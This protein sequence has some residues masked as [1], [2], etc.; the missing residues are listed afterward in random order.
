MRICTFIRPW[1]SRLRRDRRSGIAVLFALLLIPM[2]GTVGLAVDAALYFQARAAID[3]AANSAVMQAMKVAAAG[4]L[5]NDANYKTEGIAAGKQWFSVMLGNTAA[6]LTSVTPDVQITGGATLATSLTATAQVASVFGN[7]FGITKY[8]LTVAV[9]A[10]VET[11]PY[12]QVVLLLDD[13]SSMEIGASNSD[14]S[15]LSSQSPCDPSNAYYLDASHSAWSN[16]SATDYN[17]YNCSWYGTLYD[18]VTPCPVATP[19]GLSYSSFTPTPYY[20]STLPTQSCKGL[21]PMTN[22][23][24]PMTGPPCAFACHWTNTSSTDSRGGTADLFGMARRNGVT[25]R[26]DIL[27][28]AAITLLNKMQADNLSFSNLSVGIYTFEN[29]ITQIYPANCVAGTSGCE[30]GNDFT[31]AQALVGAPPVYPDVT[32][33]GILPPLAALTGNNDDTAFPEDMTSLAN[34]YVTSGGDGTSAINP[35]KVLFL[36]TD[37]FQD[38]PNLSSATARSAFDSSYCTRFKNMGYTIYVAYTPY[39]P[40]MHVVYLSKLLS[41]VE[42]SG[43]ATISYQLKACAS[44]SDDFAAVTSQ[45][46]LSSAMLTFLQQ[47]LTKAAKF[48]K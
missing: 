16:P 21:L 17:T 32:D 34:T 45:S 39:Y 7:L 43:S 35:K 38:D 2:A 10:S 18:G 37:G 12:V 31:S 36:I 22:G 20:T 13:L 26:F 28:S 1:G 33:T 4:E 30:A 14:I 40:L 19:S 46:E 9:G 29:S 15:T 8:H 42:G 5:A 44:S 48:T 47:A 27:K 3:A 41:I 23:A 6:T 25:L 11:A 24:Y